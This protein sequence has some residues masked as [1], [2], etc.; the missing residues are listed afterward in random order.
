M[1]DKTVWMIN[2]YAS[3]PAGASHTR[4]FDLANHLHRLGWKTWIFASSIEVN[5]HKQKLNRHERVRTEVYDNINFRWINTPDYK[6]NGVGRILNMLVFSWRILLKKT[7]ANL[8][9]PSVIIGSSGHALAAVAAAMLAR[10]YK[11]PF[12]FEVRDISPET[13]IALGYMHRYS[14]YAIL[15]G[16]LEKWLCRQAG[17]IISVLPKYD[18]YLMEHDIQAPPVVY[19]PN[20][21]NLD[22]IGDILPYQKRDTFRITYLGAHGTA[23]DLHTLIRAM[24]IIELSHG[25]SSIECHLIGAGPMKQA[26]MDYCAAR[27]LKQVFFHAPVTKSG[28]AKTALDTD[29]FVL[30]GRKLPSLYKYGISMNKI[31]D[32]MAMGRTIII[33]IESVN[34]PVV[35]AEAG[36][37]V[38]PECPDELADS[39]ISMARLSE[40]I[41]RKMGLNGRQYAEEKYDMKILARQL[42]DVLESV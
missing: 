31:P 22:N 40:E 37:C 13:Y 30:C 3:S 41:L 39:M 16:I 9:H 27:G 15:L 25:L 38:Q 32:Y 26:L 14:P 11:V 5:T 12:V 4:H 17:R 7:T 42:A 10:R 36:I 29:A 19:I 24:E 20:G 2:H 6:S 28:I 8:E 35:E 33:A 21:V 18:N 23:N 1:S 34:N